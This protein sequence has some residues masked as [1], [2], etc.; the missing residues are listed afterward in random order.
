[1]PQTCNTVGKY[2]FIWEISPL[3]KSVKNFQGVIATGETILCPNSTCQGRTCTGI[4]FILAQKPSLRKGGESWCPSTSKTWHFQPLPQ[5]P[6]ARQGWPWWGFLLKWLFTMTATAFGQHI[7]SN[8][9]GG[10]QQEGP[11]TFYTTMANFGRG[12]SCLWPLVDIWVVPRQQ[13]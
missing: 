8:T 1:M 7:E 11:V 3:Q 2:N 10:Y 5:N 9:A 6:L 13:A 4:L 12:H